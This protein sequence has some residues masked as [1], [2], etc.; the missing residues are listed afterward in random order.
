MK[1]TREGADVTSGIAFSSS[2]SVGIDTTAFLLLWETLLFMK[3]EAD[4]ISF[5]IA[6][7]TLHIEGYI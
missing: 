2:L 3:S 1:I 4:V 6:G 5:R 7:P